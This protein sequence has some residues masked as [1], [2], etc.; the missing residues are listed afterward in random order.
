MRVGVVGVAAAALVGATL[1][2]AP[3]TFSGPINAP[4]QGTCTPGQQCDRLA[5]VLLPDT[6]APAAQAAEPA[7]P[8]ALEPLA[9][10]LAP[11]VAPRANVPAAARVVPGITTPDAGVATVPALPPAAALPNTALPPMPGVGVPPP[12]L[13]IPPM[14]IPGIPNLAG[15]AGIP[16]GV[17]S[18]AAVV[19]GVLGVGNTAVALVTSSALAVTYVVLAYNALQD[20]GII[21]ASSAAAGTVGSM[22]LPSALPAAAVPGLPGI[23]PAALIGLAAAGGM[24]GINLPSLP[25]V[26]P[27]NLVTLA[28]AAGIPTSLPGLPG[29]SPADLT[30]L[31]AG[32]LPMLAAAGL[33]ALPGVD[34]AALAAALPTL[35]AGLPAG[36]PPLPGVDPAALAAA[37]PALAAGLPALPAGL[38]A[39]PAGLPAL[40]PPPPLPAPAIPPHPPLCT[41]GFGPIGFCVP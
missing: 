40:P 10:A 1:A 28:A 21:P 39:L 34:P 20:S 22:L 12:G 26:S 41:P 25:G 16:G 13:G 23:S 37:L 33:P 32:G 29:L 14:G 2:V 35:A 9:D 36:L 8:T 6:K 19:N 15:L 18:A 24:P 5:S 27:A 31:A 3:L 30:A 38:P 11:A 17:N 4:I 7:V